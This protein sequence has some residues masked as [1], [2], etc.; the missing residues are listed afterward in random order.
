MP[1]PLKTK[2]V[3]DYFMEELTTFS[4]KIDVHMDVTKKWP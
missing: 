4:F 1:S 2:I 3:G